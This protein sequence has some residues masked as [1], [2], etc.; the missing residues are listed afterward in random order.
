[1]NNPTINHRYY[2]WTINS[3]D[4]LRDYESTES[5]AKEQALKRTIEKLSKIFVYM[6]ISI[7]LLVY[8]ISLLR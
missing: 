2:N 3:G 6:G 8:S 7:S 5:F 1:M 4:Y